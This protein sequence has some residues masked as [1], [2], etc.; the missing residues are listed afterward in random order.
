MLCIRGSISRLRPLPYV[1]PLSRLFATSKKEH[2]EGT[3]SKRKQ[4]RQVSVE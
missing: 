4:F 3:T 2:T 1:S